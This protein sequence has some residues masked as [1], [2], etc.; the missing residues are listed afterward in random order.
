[1]SEEMGKRYDEDDNEAAEIDRRGQEV[2]GG[3]TVGEIE[4][5]DRFE[6]FEAGVTVGG[7]DNLADAVALTA[8]REMHRYL[9]P[10]NYPAATVADHPY[11]TAGEDELFEWR[12]ADTME[13]ISAM[14]AGALADDPATP[15]GG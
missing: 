5:M 10:E 11:F 2:L 13:A 7:S 6:A 1:M 4:D 9:W 8:L 3:Y 12:G 15:K 14:I